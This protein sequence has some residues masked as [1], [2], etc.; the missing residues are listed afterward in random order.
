MPRPRCPPG[1]DAGSAASARAAP[2]C[3]ACARSHQGSAAQGCLRHSSAAGSAFQRLLVGGDALRPRA[4]LHPPA[5]RRR[6]VVLA[7]AQAARSGVG[8]AGARQL[9]LLRQRWRPDPA[10][11]G[12]RGA[13]A[14]QAASEPAAQVRLPVDGSAPVWRE[15]PAAAGAAPRAAAVCG[16]GAASAAGAAGRRC[17]QAAHAAAG[18]DLCAQCVAGG[19]GDGACSRLTNANEP[20]VR[21]SLRTIRDVL[22]R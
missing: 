17:L 5:S 13:G 8:G 14:A 9:R 7:A 1:C 19:D 21:R 16:E 10:P 20:N 22:R 18:R 6:V 15:Q 2:I 3:V 4:Q 12:V 11:G